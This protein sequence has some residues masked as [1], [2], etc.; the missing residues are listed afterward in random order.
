MSADLVMASMV[1][2]AV[3]L[4]AAG[5][6]LFV[7]ARRARSPLQLLSKIAESKALLSAL[8]SKLAQGQ[9]SPEAHEVESRRAAEQLLG[10]VESAPRPPPK[11]PSLLALKAI[12]GIAAVIL[13]A[14]GIYLGAAPTPAGEASVSAAASPDG[15]A[16][17]PAAHAL[18][19]EQ[20][21]HMVDQVSEQVRQDPKDAAAWAMLAHSQDMLGRYADAS[22]AYARLTELRPG[23]AQVLA[24][25]A[26]SLAVA[27]GRSLKGEPLALVKKALVIDAKNLKAL[28]LAGTEAFERKSYSEAIDYWERAR[29]ASTEAEFTRQIEGSLSEARALAGETPGAAASAAGGAFVSGRV[30]VSESLMAKTSPD[31]TVFIFARPVLGSR[32]PVA[33]LRKKVR[34]LPLEFKLDNSNAMVPEQTLSKLSNVVIGARISK[35][36]DAM[37]QAGDLQGLSKPVKVGTAGISLEINE[38]LH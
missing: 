7:R 13:G 25:Y 2:A 20:L 15:K 5:A 24:D 27:Q 6:I 28:A 26:D 8:K 11:S 37:P 32:M 38:T 9:I 36:G 35:K 17:E 23:D 21:Q 22:Q 1:L 31:D 10:A 29:V 19:T 14:G 12:C 30:S 4:I 18:S 33:L 3:A 34:D 16:S